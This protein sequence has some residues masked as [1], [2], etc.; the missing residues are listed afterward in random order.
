[1]RRAKRVA[2]MDERNESLDSAILRKKNYDAHVRQLRINVENTFAK[3]Y[4]ENYAHAEL[5][6]DH[7]PNPWARPM[8]EIP[9]TYIYPNEAYNQIK[10]DLIQRY[11]L[12]AMDTHTLPITYKEIE[13]LADWPAFNFPYVYGRVR[14][15]HYVPEPETLEEYVM[16]RDR[17]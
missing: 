15:Q 8:F 16:T 2:E 12:Y 17:S 11:E 1:M 3:I 6:R 10:L 13:D 4:S 9:V 14:P 5:H 7:S